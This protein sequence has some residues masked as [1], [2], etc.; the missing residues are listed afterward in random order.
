MSTNI[1][2]TENKRGYREDYGIFE[3]VFELKK[4]FFLATRLV[5]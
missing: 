5:V 3:N 4:N 1:S 2:I